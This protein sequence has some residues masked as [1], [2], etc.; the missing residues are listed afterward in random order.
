MWTVYNSTRSY[1][2]TSAI[3]VYMNKNIYQRFNEGRKRLLALT[4]RV[5]SLRKHCLTV[6]SQKRKNLTYCS[7]MFTYSIYNIFTRCTALIWLSLKMFVVCF[8]FF[9]W[10]VYL[11]CWRC[12]TL[13]MIMW[14]ESEAFSLLFAYKCKRNRVCRSV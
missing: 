1:R 13:K 7:S 2:K 4:N 5:S 3:E 8:L 6:T 11:W 14:R 12:G 9:R 10:Y